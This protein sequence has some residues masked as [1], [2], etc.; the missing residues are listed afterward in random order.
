MAVLEHHPTVTAIQFV[1]AKVLVR[2]KG[3]SLEVPMMGQ[4]MESGWAVRSGCQWGIETGDGSAE[5]IAIAKEVA[6]GPLKSS[7]KVTTMVP[8]L[9]C[10][11]GGTTVVDLVTWLDST[12]ECG[13]VFLS[14]ARWEWGWALEMDTTLENWLVI[15]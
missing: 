5:P 7:S 9:G 1:L 15:G 8:L 2:K 11:L 14:V 12:L 4:L 10:W 6:S 13:L 3:L